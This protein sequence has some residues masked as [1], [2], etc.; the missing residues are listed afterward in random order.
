MEFTQIGKSYESAK[1]GPVPLMGEG[2]TSGKSTADLF[3]N[4]VTRDD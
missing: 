4:S 1:V 3:T 2:V